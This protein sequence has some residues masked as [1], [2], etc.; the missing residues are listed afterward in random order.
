MKQYQ[1][2]FI[3]QFISWE[4]KLSIHIIKHSDDLQVYQ[5][6]W[7]F[8]S[9]FKLKVTL[10]LKMNCYYFSILQNYIQF[11]FQI[12]LGFTKNTLNY[13]III[14]HLDCFEEKTPL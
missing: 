1:T 7:L 3:D 4:V 8:F 10:L 12:S 14:S 5:I 13:D 11:K 6:M 9:E 2:G